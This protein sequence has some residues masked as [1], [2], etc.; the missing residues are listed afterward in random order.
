MIEEPVTEE[1]QPT[2][3]LPAAVPQFWQ[4]LAALAAE[5]LSVP[6]PRPLPVTVMDLNDY[7]TILL[8]QIGEVL[9]EA[10]QNGAWR[11]PLAYDR[12]EDLRY[13]LIP[14]MLRLLRLYAAD[15]KIS[16]LLAAQVALLLFAIRDMVR[17]G[18]LPVLVPFAKKENFSRIS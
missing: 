17:E 8:S 18:K 3:E 13:V 7:S 6:P 15:G 14:E 16:D 9:A 4:M 12:G 5:P 11:L 1:V 2:I 10:D